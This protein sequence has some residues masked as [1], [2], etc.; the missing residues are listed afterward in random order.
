MGWL[1][2]V[3]DPEERAR[4]MQAED[5]EIAAAYMK[6]IYDRRRV[7]VWIA[8][9]PEEY[10]VIKEKSSR[11]LKEHRRIIRRIWYAKNKNY[12]RI[13]IP[14][15]ASLT[16]RE[17]DIRRAQSKRRRSIKAGLPTTLTMH[18]WQEIVEFYHRQCVYCGLIPKYLTQDHIVPLLKGGPYSKEN[19]V[20]S[21]RPCNSRKHTGY[22]P[23]VVSPMPQHLD[24][25]SLAI[26]LD[27]KLGKAKSI[28]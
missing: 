11:E 12:L 25:I 10:K 22:L 1:D 24:A 13:F 18:E 28:Q 23:F 3:K 26:S 21:C 16:E 27:A 17:K 8:A 20:P 19:I 9:H 14:P 7:A 2:L 5:D 15:Y 4:I 6:G